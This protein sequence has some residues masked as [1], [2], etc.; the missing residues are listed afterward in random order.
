MNAAAGPAFHDD[1]SP[2]HRAYGQKGQYRRLRIERRRLLL[3]YQEGAKGFAV[4]VRPRNMKL[5]SLL[6]RGAAHGCWPFQGTRAV[7]AVSAGD[8]GCREDPRVVWRRLR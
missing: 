7:M 6:Q 3:A 4:L 1:G 2:C 5:I 8:A